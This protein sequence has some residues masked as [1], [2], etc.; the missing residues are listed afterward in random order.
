[1]ASRPESVIPDKVI[2]LLSP[3]FLFL[4]TAVVPEVSTSKLSTATFPTNVTLLTPETTAFL[5]PS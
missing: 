5:F 4:N 2:G 1:L 3:T